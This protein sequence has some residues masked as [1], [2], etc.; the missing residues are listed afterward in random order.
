MSADFDLA[1][2]MTEVNCALSTGNDADTT[3]V[4]PYFFANAGHSRPPTTCPSGPLSCRIAT[5]RLVATAASVSARNGASAR[6]ASSKKRSHTNFHARTDIN[7]WCG[8]QAVT[9]GTRCRS[10][11]SAPALTSA[12]VQE[13]SSATAW[14]REISVSTLLALT[15]ASVL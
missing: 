10:A 5:L 1:S 4:Q 11:T 8:S 14:S 13:P 6:S 7:A 15:L 3:T 12:G 2:A 9:I